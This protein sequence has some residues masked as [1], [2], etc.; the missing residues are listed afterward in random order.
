MTEFKSVIEKF[1]FEQSELIA[2]F[3][4]NQRINDIR[5]AG[6]IVLL[7][8]T[9]VMTSEQVYGLD[10]WST[11]L[12]EGDS[13]YDALLM[14]DGYLCRLDHKT[15]EKRKLYKRPKTKSWVY[16]VYYPLTNET[17]KTMF[18]FSRAYLNH[19][20]ERVKNELYDDEMICVSDVRLLESIR[21]YIL[22]NDG[23][24]GFD[25]PLW[26]IDEV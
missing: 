12:N 4:N 25:L 11:Y 16:E 20:I 22:A 24:G 5:N 6:G 2:T 26:E 13:P 18:E 7:D 8:Q 14:E 3:N 23:E 19:T 9:Y 15:G 17:L 1:K 10:D 21:N